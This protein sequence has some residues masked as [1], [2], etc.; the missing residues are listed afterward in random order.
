M[1]PRISILASVFIFLFTGIFGQDLQ[2]KYQVIISNFIDCVKNDQKEKISDMISYPF[3]R[4]YPIP[5]IKNKQEF[6]ERY[7]EIFDDTL[8]QMVIKSKPATDWSD[9]GWRGIMLY[10]GDIWID[11]NGRLMGI[12]YQSKAEL[13]MRE[14]LISNEKEK[15]HASLSQ[16][17]Y[18]ICVLETSKFRIRIDELGNNNIRYSSWS[19]NKA[20][21]EKPDLVLTKGEFIPKGSGGNHSYRFRNADYIYECSIIVMG[22]DNAPPA[23]LTIYKGDKEILSQKAM[24]IVK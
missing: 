8:K 13:S 24:I 23:R 20:M 14:K 5:S 19:I 6:I 18:P 17:Q 3:K 12:N 21:N 22:E 11:F 15:I 7:N 4:K 1:T 16:F 9:V 10:R 2:K